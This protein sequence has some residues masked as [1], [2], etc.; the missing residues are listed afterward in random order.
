VTGSPYRAPLL[1]ALIVLV[2][3][4]PRLALACPQCAGNDKGGIGAGVVIGAMILIPFPIVWFVA[5]LIR[6]HADS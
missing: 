5:R 2:L 3:A 6:K 1:T 4:V